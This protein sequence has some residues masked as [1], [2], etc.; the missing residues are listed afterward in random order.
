VNII[1][2]LDDQKLLGAAVKDPATFFAWRALL[3]G[4]F[5]LPDD[6]AELFRACTGRADPPTAAFAVCWLVCG[7]RGGKSF[8]MALVAVFFAI[9]KDWRPFLAPGERAV[10]LLVA[11]DRE[12]AKIL[13]RYISGILGNAM[14]VQ[15]VEGE[16]ADSIELT[17]SVAIEVATCSYRTVRGRSV[18]VALLDEVAFWRSESTANPDKEVWRA[19]R[20]SMATFGS[21]GLAI[22][23][24]SPYSRRGLLYD[25]WKRYFGKAD[26][27]NLV[28]QAATKVMNPTI[29]DEFIAAEFEADPAS[30]EAE[31]NAQFRSDVE[32]F[33]TLEAIEACVP[34]GVTVRAPLSGVTYFG[35]VDPS[36]GSQA[37][38]TMGIAHC[39]G[40]AVILDLVAERRPPFS[41]DAVVAEFAEVLKA[42][43]IATV[44]GDR[45]AGEWP[46]ERFRAHGIEYL[47]AD[48]SRSDIYIECLPRVTAK[49]VDL[50]DNRKLIAQLASLERRTA[51]S[52]KDSVDHPPN[53]HDDVANSACGAIVIAQ[54]RL[55]QP[56]VVSPIFITAATSE[57]GAASHDTM[58]GLYA[59]KRSSGFSIRRAI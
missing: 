23:G 59:D 13:R 48:K 21:E 4:L 55:F 53:G 36:G 29:S 11:A 8:V 7:R 19:I 31:Y 30:A 57:I 12:Q 32:A 1:E 37:S 39:E 54:P 45:Y 43:R 58:S 47:P 41:P 10:V 52:G 6:E 35:F 24:S 50:L 40:D 16:T 27:T 33:L 42:Y 2:A 56:V 17:G 18:C 51:R 9:F 15:H 38:K 46:R 5:G 28:W 25:N 3:K 20:A 26:A 44:R 14:F 22:V 49:R 34:S